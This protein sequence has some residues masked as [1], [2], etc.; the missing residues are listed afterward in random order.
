LLPTLPPEQEDESAFIKFA[1]ARSANDYKDGQYV[2]ETESWLFGIGSTEETWKVVFE[3]VFVDGLS[4]P[5]GKDRPFTFGGFVNPDAPASSVFRYPFAK[6]TFEKAITTI[7]SGTTVIPPEER[8]EDGHKSAFG[9]A[10]AR[11]HNTDI[12][13]LKSSLQ[14]DWHII[15]DENF[16]LCYPKQS[17]DR[18]EEDDL[19]SNAELDKFNEELARTILSYATGVRQLLV[20]KDWTQPLDIAISF[21]K[22]CV[23]LAC[24]SPTGKPFAQTQ[25]QPGTVTWHRTKFSLDEFIP[26]LPENWSTNTTAVVG[27]DSDKFYAA[28]T[29]ELDESSEEQYEAMQ[30][31]LEQKINDTK[32]ADAKKTAVPKTIFHSKVEGVQCRLDYENIER[33]FRFTGYVEPASFGNVMALAR[34]FLQ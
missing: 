26:T 10:I 31:Y 3:H 29:L 23:F 5:S 16:V 1:R 11:T 32:Q 20:S 8:G 19:P 33:G 34:Q 13:E 17:E 4:T 12:E 6:E 7:K 21:E 28:F 27:Y 14:D 15:S 18:P 22:N 30:Q 25:N 9:T 24:S 2:G